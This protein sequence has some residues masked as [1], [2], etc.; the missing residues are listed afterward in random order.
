MLSV[1]HYV[2]ALVSSRYQSRWSSAQSRAI[3][4]YDEIRTDIQI[5]CFIPTTSNY[6]DCVSL[7]SS[8]TG[9]LPFDVAYPPNLFPNHALIKEPAT[10]AQ[11][12]SMTIS[13]S[14]PYASFHLDTIHVQ[15][16]DR[17]VLLV[18]DVLN[19]I[20]RHLNDDLSYR[21]EQQLFHWLGSWR[22]ARR[23][24]LLGPWRT[25]AG[26]TFMGGSEFHL[27]FV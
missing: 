2:P 17:C 18:C 16:K 12:R 20:Y 14:A 24:E 8:L 23:L 6:V 7:N 25:F 5:P 1:Q 22:P 9:L 4:V 26:L 11:L 27:T 10:N 15:R 13:V 19:A 21:E 3:S